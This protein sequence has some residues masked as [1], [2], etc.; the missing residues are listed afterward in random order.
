[1]A[2]SRWDHGRRSIW[3]LTLATGALTQVTYGNDSFYPVWMPDGRRLLFTQFPQDREQPDTSMWSVATDGAGR[4]EPIGR[5]VGGYPTGTS[6][7]GRTLYYRLEADA[8]HMDIMQLTLD[9]PDASPTPVVATP[10]TEQAALPSPDG[11]WLA[12]ST[13]TSGTEQVRVL[14]L[15]DRTASIQVS[16]E[17]GQ[18]IRWTAAGSQLFYR[19][20]NAVGV[21]EVGRGGPIPASKRAAFRLPP[22]VHGPPDVMPDGAHAVVIRGG[23]IYQDLVIVAGGLRA[24][25]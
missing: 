14:D 6:A 13:E 16:A 20:G 10:A 19:D 1:M 11:R 4:A 23:P 12:Y 24:R 5:Q 22:D 25:Q 3:A 8:V 18:P 15:S 21:T 9:S 2:V 17:G 7:D